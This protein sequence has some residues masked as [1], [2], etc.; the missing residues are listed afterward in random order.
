[1]ATKIRV[2]KRI[3]S[4][5]KKITNNQIKN[6]EK[7]TKESV[8]KISVV[9]V[10]PKCEIVYTSYVLCGE[11]VCKS[12]TNSPNRVNCVIW[13]A[14]VS[15]TPQFGE[16]VMCCVIVTF[17]IVLGCELISHQAGQQA[18]KSHTRTTHAARPD[19]RNC[20]K[21]AIKKQFVL[22]APSRVFG[23]NLEA[24]DNCFLVEGFFGLMGI[25][26]SRLRGVN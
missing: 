19:H 17:I 9:H 18:T 16:C 10:I 14:C 7:S 20:I 5:K 15:S 21:V 6:L 13:S 1:M 4:D 26:L 23:R 2:H 12:L 22:A 3:P 11:E 8:K 25:L 24:L